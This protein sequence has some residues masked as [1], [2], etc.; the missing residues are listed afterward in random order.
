VGKRADIAL[1]AGDP[2]DPYGSLIRLRPSGVQL[3]MVDGKALYGDASLIAAGPAVPG[4]E[5]ITLCNA[6]KFLCAAETS[7]SN[8]L[9]ETF[10]QIQQVLTNA[11]SDYDNNVAGPAGVAPF[12]PIAPLAKCP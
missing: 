1:V 10:V 12:S 6:S 3:V 7:T 11:L 2:A 8:F 4:C 9:N 5:T